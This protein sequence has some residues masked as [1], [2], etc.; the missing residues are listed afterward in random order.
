MKIF[1][2]T[3]MSVER[4]ANKMLKN[5]LFQ[6]KTAEDEKT[7]NIKIVYDDGV[8]QYVKDVIYNFCRNL[9]RNYQ[10]VVPLN[11]YVVN[12]PH[13][14]NEAGDKSVCAYGS[15]WKLSERGAYIKMAV[16]D[17]D[18]LVRERGRYDA[19]FAILEPLSDKIIIYL[20]WTKQPCKRF[21][22]LNALFACIF[23]KIYKERLLE[24]YMTKIEDNGFL[25][26][27]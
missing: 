10:F 22:R 7:K 12:K 6:R 3:R 14:D 17:Y 1:R 13:L 24:A 4:M 18:D 27:D 16:G 19:V 11:I 26:G 25:N 23:V 20:T 9:E 15:P 2:I 5:W 8:D 21:V